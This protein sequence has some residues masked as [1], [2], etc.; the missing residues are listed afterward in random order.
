MYKELIVYATMI[1]EAGGE[2]LNL[3]VNE[4]QEKP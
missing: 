1:L 2:H 3:Y 4:S